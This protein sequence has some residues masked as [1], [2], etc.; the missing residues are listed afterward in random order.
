MKSS[1]KVTKNILRLSR[2]KINN[3]L[4]K[5]NVRFFGSNAHA[6][7]DHHHAA[8]HE[9]HTDG[10]SHHEPHGEHGHHGHDD[11]HGHH[12]IT[13]EVDF[14]K[15]HVKNPPAVCILYYSYSR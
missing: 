6:K 8:H 12:E 11:H 14:H 7:A 10:H 4:F 3:N 5:T 15:V 9:S 13:G 1:S 2:F